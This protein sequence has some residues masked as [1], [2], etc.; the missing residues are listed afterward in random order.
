MLVVIVVII[1][2]T[3]EERI[4][5]AGDEVRPVVRHAEQG[6]VDIRAVEPD[7]ATKLPTAVPAAGEESRVVV[8]R[9]RRN[10]GRDRP[11]QP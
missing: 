10:E 3:L 8:K 7:V 9:R 11:Q 2:A 4:F 5:I 1:V 6:R